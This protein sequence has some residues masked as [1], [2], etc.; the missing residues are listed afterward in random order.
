M[1]DPRQLRQ[2]EYMVLAILLLA[3]IA[4]LCALPGCATLEKPRETIAPSA[5][6]RPREL[7][8]VNIPQAFRERN[9]APYR[10]G[11][12]VHAS[13]VM[14]LRWQGHLQ[15]ADWW[16][17][18]YHSGETWVG[19]ERKLNAA[20]VR[21]AQ[22]IRGDVAFLEWAIETRRGAAVV[23]QAG[24][25]MVCLVHLDKQRAGLLDNNS[26]ARI[27]W[28]SREDFLWEWRQAGG[29]AVTPVYSPP[30]AKPFL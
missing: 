11:S 18:T 12:C 19:L 4:L 29:W 1:A 26:P 23:V 17:R 22:T 8:V 9:W 13:T 25:H 10:Q 20:G 5:S 7:P 30:P 6:Q 15:L 21:Y 3:G 16:R 24:R 14:L 28:R 27:D 2:A